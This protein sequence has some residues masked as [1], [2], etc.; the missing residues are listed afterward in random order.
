MRIEI[1]AL[2]NEFV[3]C[4]LVST[5]RSPYGLLVFTTPFNS[6]T[7]YRCGLLITTGSQA[8]YEMYMTIIHA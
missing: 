7:A 4:E 8:M 1:I 5:Y 6:A 3:I 2:S